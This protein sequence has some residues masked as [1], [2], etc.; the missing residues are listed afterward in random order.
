MKKRKVLIGFLVLAV[1][2]VAGY[3]VLTRAEVAE[4]DRIRLSGNI[5]LTEVEV[6]FKIPGKIVELTV[7]EGD[8]VEVSQVIAVYPEAPPR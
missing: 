6:A 1:L 3:L 8:Q 4:R 5:E 7:E 2:S